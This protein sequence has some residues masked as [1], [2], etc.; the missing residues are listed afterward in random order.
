MRG[1]TIIAA[2]ALAGCAVPPAAGGNRAPAA[3]EARLGQSA[4]L[5]NVAVRPLAVI[6]DS[7]CPRN[8]TCVWAGRLRL[9]AAISGVAGEVELTLSEPYPLPGGGTITLV[10][11][12]P[13]RWQN[14][15]P[16]REAGPA[17]RFTFRRD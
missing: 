4:R 13:E 17:A 10:A 14:P 16:G 15:P 5:G 7:R 1:T 3:A 12:S 11:A 9:R 6:E 2:L 8:V